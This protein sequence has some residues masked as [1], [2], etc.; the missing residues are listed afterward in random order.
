MKCWEQLGGYG[1]GVG[2]VSGVLG[3]TG[4]VGG[5]KWCFGGVLGA[6]TGLGGIGEGFGG[7]G[8]ARDPPS[9][10]LTPSF[11]PPAVMQRSRPQGWRCLP[12]R[13]P[14]PSSAWTG[15]CPVTRAG[16][17]APLPS[18][19][20]G[21]ALPRPMARGGAPLPLACPPA[22]PPCPCHPTSPAGPPALEQV[23][24]GGDGGASVPLP[25]GSPPS[26]L[27]PYSSRHYS[28]LGL[29]PRG[30]L[31]PHTHLLPPP[32][33]R[34]P[35][36][37]DPPFLEPPEPLR[38]MAALRD[39]PVVGGFLAKRRERPHKQEVSWGGPWGGV[40]VGGVGCLAPR[41][42]SPTDPLL[43]PPRTPWAAL[44]LGTPSRTGRGSHGGGRAQ[45]RG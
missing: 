23:R 22:P 42:P 34:L 17:A 44:A 15:W 16:S 7:S 13:R 6:D 1:A 9:A 31:P 10:C 3:D 24:P 29:P 19:G 45:P 43:L 21:P 41:F 33:P 18:W 27:V 11:P 14:Q 20:P 30:P 8:R 38:P 35:P 28:P 26:S 37:P 12:P 4:R 39:V 2:G 25:H 40:A 36:A 32:P 5:G